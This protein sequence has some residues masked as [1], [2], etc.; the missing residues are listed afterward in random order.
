VHFVVEGDEDAEATRA[1]GGRSTHGAHEVHAD[2]A[3]QCA[4]WTLR[5]DHDHRLAGLER[6]VQEV[7]RLLERRGA[8]RDDEAGKIG[9]LLGE[10]VNGGGQLQ[11]LRRTNRSAADAAEGHRHHF[12]KARDLGNSPDH[13]L[14]WQLGAKIGI[15]E[16]VEAVAPK[17]GDGA[18]ATN[19]GNDR[20]CGHRSA[21][22]PRSVRSQA[23][24]AQ[25][26][27]AS[28]F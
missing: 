19:G 28:S 22:R 12:G 16:H 13:L 8:V 2:V 10:A 5:A 25:A 20:S 17:R 18:A 6:Q 21:F 3:A 7:G 11:P 14:D 24:A 15:V 1:G 26:A 9:S 23:A 4:G 27:R